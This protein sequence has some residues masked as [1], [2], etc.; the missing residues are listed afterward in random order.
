MLFV[1]YSFV[2]FVTFSQA[3]DSFWSQVQIQISVLICWTCMKIQLFQL[4]LVNW[5][6]PKMTTAK[7]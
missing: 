7:C 3:V 4:I 2:T 1:V 6:I 5:Y